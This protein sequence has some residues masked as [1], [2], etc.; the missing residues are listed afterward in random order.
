MA[1]QLRFVTRW[2]RP[3]RF[4]FE[5]REIQPELVFPGWK[6]PPVREEAGMRYAVWANADGAGSW[7]TLDCKHEVRTLKMAIAGS[8]GVSHGTAGRISSLLGVST[9]P[10]HWFPSPAG[11][12][13]EV[14]EFDGR[15]CLR[16]S[17][18]TGDRNQHLWL[19]RSSGL[20]L[21][22]D[23]LVEFSTQG[24]IDASREHVERLRQSIEQDPASAEQYGSLL[25]SLEQH[26]ARAAEHPPEPFT[27]RSS[28]RYQP[29]IDPELR[30]E[31]FVF[32]PPG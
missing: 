6:V 16:I 9:H 1:N 30:E 28:T 2:K 17:M 18:R 24:Q 3:E 8:S 29:R 14:V 23:E 31:D 19:E 32:V 5:F 27:T 20:V 21:R 7:S 26:V 13:G 10:A 25:E 15:E 11:F 4:F 12:E 22:F